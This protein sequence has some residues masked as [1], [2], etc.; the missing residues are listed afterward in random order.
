MNL[1]DQINADIKS[2]MLAREKERLS[3]LRNIKKY[4]IE[5]KTAKGGSDELSDADA[6]K[7]IMKLAKQGKDSA[8]IFKE[9]NRQDLYDD[10]M[11]QVEVYEKYLPEHMS[12]EELTKVIK[13]IIEKTGA[14]SM[15]DMGKVMG[16]A[17]KE[18][19]GKADGK[20][21]SDKVRSLLG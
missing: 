1:F 4:F 15:K 14:S 17:T 13:Q 20:L 10:E 18:L 12:D 11:L 9:Q 21:V 16:M 8:N 7:V 6:L 2:A 5:T 19:S 3:A